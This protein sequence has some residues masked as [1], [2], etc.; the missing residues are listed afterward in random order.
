MCGIIQR[1]RAH[2]TPRYV[3]PDW[4]NA[5]P[6]VV[7]EDTHVAERK[8]L[9]QKPQEKTSDNVPRRRDTLHSDD[10]D[11]N[12]QFTENKSSRPRRGTRRPIRYAAR[13]IV[14]DMYMSTIF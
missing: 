5:K 7:T 14:N 9:G 3:T 10:S 13:T 4:E 2:G 12:E 8:N 6:A 11:S 1:C